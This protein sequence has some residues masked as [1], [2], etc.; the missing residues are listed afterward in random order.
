MLCCLDVAMRW[1]TSFIWLYFIIIFYYCVENIIIYRKRGALLG[2]VKS[3]KQ[4]AKKQRKKME[5]SEKS[6]K[7]RHENENSELGVYLH[8][9]DKFYFLTPLFKWNLR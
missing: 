7:V 5:K 4:K 9:I 8:R 2:K 6:E 3:D 1:K